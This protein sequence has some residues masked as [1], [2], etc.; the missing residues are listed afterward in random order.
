M[1]EGRNVGNMNEERNK[2]KNKDQKEENGRNEG[3][4]KE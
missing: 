3:D 1:T 4:W 2:G